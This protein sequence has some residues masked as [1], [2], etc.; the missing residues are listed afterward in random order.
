MA[1]MGAEMPKLEL[2]DDAVA[3]LAPGWRH[4]RAF[5]TAPR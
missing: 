3:R 2:D 4:E 1:E 5:C